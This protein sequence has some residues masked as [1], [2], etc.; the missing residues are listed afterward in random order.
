MNDSWSLTKRCLPRFAVVAGIAML[1]I[2]GCTKHA[3]MGTVKGKV[4]LNDKPFSNARVTLMSL[5]SGKASSGEIQTDGSFQLSQPLPVGK[6][7][8]FLSSKSLGETDKG[9]AP[10][11]IDR[12]VP[13]KYWSESGSDISVEIKEG[14]NDVPVNLKK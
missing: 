9:P 13:E 8:V 2:A 10:E 7:K 12:S 6:Y 11:V 5:Q 3:P 1:A 14:E 4:L